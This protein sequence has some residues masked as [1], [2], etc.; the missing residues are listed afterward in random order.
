MRASRKGIEIFDAAELDRALRDEIDRCATQPRTVARALKMRDLLVTRVA[1]YTGLRWRNLT[2]LRLGCEVRYDGERFAIS[3]AAAA[4]K[5][6]QP[7]GFR[8]ARAITPALHAYIEH[9]RP[10]LLNGHEDQGHLWPTASGRPACDDTVSRA[11]QGVTRR[12]IGRAINPH[13]IRHTMATEL[14]LDD[15]LALRTAAAALGHSST[16]SVNEVYDRFG[17]EGAHR[18]W[19]R[20]LLAHLAR[21]H[22]R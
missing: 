3:I 1:L 15:P 9:W 14:L 5:T 16:R 10:L 19:R 22:R 2:K 18:F 13:L 7:I 20:V 11:I 17:S 4:T 6:R 8:L 21:T 12:L